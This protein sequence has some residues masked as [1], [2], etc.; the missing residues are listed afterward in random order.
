MSDG[1]TTGGTRHFLFLLA[2]ARRNGNSETLARRTVQ[3]LNGDQTWLRLSDLPLEPFEDIRHEGDGTYP[4]PERHAQT[5]LNAT[6]GASDLIFVAPLY[7][8]GLPASAKLY[9]DHWSGWM[10]IPGLGF[11]E[12]MAGKTM[13]AITA[14]S[15]EDGALAD[16][17]F[18]TL[19]HSAGYMSMR[20]GGTLLGFANRPGDIEADAEACAAA[21]LFFAGGAH[22]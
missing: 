1:N 13:W 15:D 19:R 6:L 9:L 3:G 20:W 11:K 21:E 5:L 8:Y 4:A 18:A 17:L 22:G 16:P 10:R 7:W 14:F 2:S 12:R